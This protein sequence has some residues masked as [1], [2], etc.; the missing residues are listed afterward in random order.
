MRD[1]SAT[2]WAA[3]EML[4]DAIDATEQEA[5][6]KT[7]EMAG[8]LAVKR[9]DQV[10]AVNWPVVLDELLDELAATHIE[11]L[12]KYMREVNPLQRMKYD[13]KKKRLEVVSDKVALQL[14]ANVT[15]F[16]RLRGL[17]LNQVRRAAHAVKKRI[18][19]GGK[20]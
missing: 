18:T 17:N 9:N 2:D 12:D 11:E 7:E 20:K 14:S 3:I 16:P 19:K 5:K 10:D 8:D 15:T 6:N 4:C 13:R 1:L